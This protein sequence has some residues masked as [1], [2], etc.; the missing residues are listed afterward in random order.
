[1]RANRQKHR[2]EDEAPCRDRSRSKRAVAMARARDWRDQRRP[3]RRM[4]RD[5]ERIGQPDRQFER[6]FG[7]VRSGAT[8]SAWRDR[9]DVDRRSEHARVRWQRPAMCRLSSQHPRAA[10]PPTYPLHDGSLC[11]MNANPTPL[12]RNLTLQALAAALRESCQMSDTVVTR[13]APS[14]TGY[15]HI[16]GARTALFNWLYAR[17]TGGRCCCASRTPTASARPMPPPPRF[18][19]G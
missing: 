17:H 18:S 5:V 8:A 1:M 14:P 12:A 3:R 2:H 10:P 13:F 16:G 6:H 11:Y 4:R 7:R 19:T 9:H 15:L